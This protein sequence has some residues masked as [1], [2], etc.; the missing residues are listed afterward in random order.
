MLWSFIIS[1]IINLVLTA[2]LHARPPKGFLEGPYLLLSAGALQADFDT[3]QQSGQKVGRDVEPGAGFVFGWNITD[4]VA[5]EL[6]GIYSTNINAGRREHIVGATIG[7][8][9]LFLLD[10]LTD[11]GSFHLFPFLRGGPGFRIF[12]LPGNQLSTD[13]LVSQVGLGGSVGG[14]LGLH[15]KKYLYAG[16]DV[17]GDLFSYEDVQQNLD[18][19]TPALADQLIYR[20]GFQ[21]TFGAS[22]FIGVHY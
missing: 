4:A 3:D 16:I 21:P 2:D 15:W 22:L 7:A 8:R 9:Y 13:Q 10:A 19:L 1:L 11:L 5:P 17:Q 14:G 6:Y 12:V 20:G 18:T